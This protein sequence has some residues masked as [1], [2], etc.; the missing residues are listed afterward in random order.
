MVGIGGH[1]EIGFLYLHG[2]ADNTEDMTK[3]INLQVSLFGS[4]AGLIGGTGFTCLI[5]QTHVGRTHPRS[6]LGADV[7]PAC[8]RGE[9]IERVK[10]VLH[11]KNYN[12]DLNSLITPPEVLSRDGQP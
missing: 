11:V 10:Q 1:R 4:M 3:M 2:Q 8:E 5:W 6:T 12:T 9:Q 7:G